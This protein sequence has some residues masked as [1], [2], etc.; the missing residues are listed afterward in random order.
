MSA[1]KQMP[2]AFVPGCDRSWID[3]KGHW[4]RKEA[5]TYGRGFPAYVSQ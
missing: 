2:A 5:G 1:I 3:W 4:R